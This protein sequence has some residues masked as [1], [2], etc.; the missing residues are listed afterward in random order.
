MRTFPLAN[1]Q[2]SVSDSR[3]NYLTLRNNYI[4]IA[5]QAESEYEELFQSK[6]RDMKHLVEEGLSD[7]YQ[8]IFEKIA[9]ASDQLVKMGDYTST[10]ES[11]F[12]DHFLDR[13]RWEEKFGRV[14]DKYMDIELDAENLKQYRQARKDSR[15]LIVG[16]GFGI[17]GAA[18]GMAIAGAA[19]LATGAL[20]GIFNSIGNAISNAKKAKKIEELFQDFSTLRTLT[21]AIYDDVEAIHI[22]LYEILLSKGLVEVD[23]FISGQD[24]KKADAIVRNVKEGRIAGEKARLG[25][26]SQAISLDPTDLRS[27]ELLMSEKLCSQQEIDSLSQHLLVDLNSTKCKILLSHYTDGSDYDSEEVIAST[28]KEI[29]SHAKALCCSDYES[30]I[31]IGQQR[32]DELDAIARTFEGVEYATREDK[33]QAISEKEALAGELAGVGLTGFAEADVSLTNELFDNP[34]DEAQIDA[35]KSEIAG[36]EYKYQRVGEIVDTLQQVVDQLDF[37]ARTFENVTYETKDD[38]DNVVSE[39]AAIIERLENAGLNVEILNATSLDGIGIVDDASLQEISENLKASDFTYKGTKQLAKKIDAIVKAVRTY[40]KHTYATQAEANQAEADKGQLDAIM[41]DVDFRDEASLKNTLD[42][43]LNTNHVYIGTAEQIDELKLVLRA[44]DR[45]QKTVYG[46]EYS[47]R[48]E[49]DLARKNLDAIVT[50]LE[51]IAKHFQ[52]RKEQSFFVKGSIPE[53]KLT[54][55]IAKVKNLYGISLSENDVFAY[56]DET[57]FGGGD[58]GICLTHS[59][60]I[61][62]KDKLGVFKLTDIVDFELVGLV[63]KAIQFTDVEKGQFKYVGTQ[64]S[65]QGESMNAHFLLAALK[66]ASNTLSR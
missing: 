44:I 34:L 1:Q 29:H 57:L 46:R 48:E 54:A 18:K 53:N 19:N 15:G 32:L 31:R 3:Y 36:N 11:F 39:K 6:Y 62:T 56:I 61:I 40:E 59:D 25:A 12:N 8:L 22:T 45:E 20:H 65:Q 21:S 47:S 23:G 37:I 26:L 41:G 55:F 66:P 35:L 60:L 64:G 13:T 7:G 9:I 49:A 14:L 30:V 33:A 50:Q 38:V 17:E 27:Y 4:Q 28:I 24:S 10:P 16:G 51:P 5:R 2:I 63:N 43:L 58:T 42:Q 52:S